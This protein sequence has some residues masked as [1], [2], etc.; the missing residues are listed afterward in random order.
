MTR[1]LITGCSDSRCIGCNL[2]H[3]YRS[4]LHFTPHSPRLKRFLEVHHSTLKFVNNIY[5]FFKRVVS[6]VPLSVELYLFFDGLVPTDRWVITDLIFLGHFCFSI[7]FVVASV[8]TMSY[9]EQ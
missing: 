1:A 3:K 5:A 7:R 4:P 6:Q 2:G 9:D 8:H